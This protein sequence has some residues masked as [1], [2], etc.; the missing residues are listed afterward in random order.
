MEKLRPRTGKTCDENQDPKPHLVTLGPGL[1]AL[2]QGPLSL[3]C[4]PVP[5]GWAGDSRLTSW[6]EALEQ[7]VADGEVGK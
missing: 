3:P 2:L 4:L 1:L 7:T 6:R 5:G